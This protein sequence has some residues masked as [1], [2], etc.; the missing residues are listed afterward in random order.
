MAQIKFVVAYSE[1]RV[2][3]IENQ[4]PWYLPNDFR[5]FKQLTLNQR[6]LMGRKTY[7]SIGRPLPQREMV[8]LSRNPDF[9]SDYA[10][11]ISSLEAL[12]PLQH[13]LYVIGGAE[14]YR[15]LLAKAEVI[16]ATEVKTTLVGDAFFPALP[17][18]EWIE[19]DREVHPQ[20]EKHAFQYDFVTFQRKT[21]F[22]TA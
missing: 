16:Y 11:R 14:I 22:K 9:Q 8:V 1:N 2:I 12:F 21:K 19:I 15:L 7:E 4:M 20:D 13:D 18:A 5:H 6:V 17:A 10:Q 3:G